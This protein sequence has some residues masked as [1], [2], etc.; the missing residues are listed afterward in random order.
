ME[1]M[2]TLR[3]SNEQGP[4]RARMLLLVIA[5]ASLA[6]SVS[7]ADTA[8]S[9]SPQLMFVQIADN[10]GVDTEAKTLRLMNVSQQTVYFSDRPVRIAG[11]IK[12]ADYLEEWT[13]KA[14]KDNF[15][16]NPPNAALSVYEAGKPENTLA[17]I[18]ISQPRVDGSDLLYSYKLIEG[19][20]PASGGATALFIDR[21]GA[22]G[23]AGP[24]FHGVGAGRRGPGV[25]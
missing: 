18:E 22:G 11:H 8:A 14:G 3:D 6:A 4:K 2:K 15:G 23:G 17:I 10:L 21:I 7:T 16:D 24:G 25:R 20:L 19:E 5:S 12:M 13:A 9:E 1:P